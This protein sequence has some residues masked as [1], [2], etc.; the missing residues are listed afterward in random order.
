MRHHQGPAH[1]PLGGQTLMEFHHARLPSDPSRHEQGC[2]RVADQLGEVLVPAP[3][4]TTARQDHSV[5]SPQRRAWSTNRR[6]FAETVHSAAATGNSVLL[7]VAQRRSRRRVSGELSRGA[8]RRTAGRVSSAWTRPWP[9]LRRDGRRIGRQ[10][11]KRPGGRQDRRARRTARRD[12]ARPLGAAT[13][14]TWP[15]VAE[16]SGH[17]VEEHNHQEAHEKQNRQLTGCPCT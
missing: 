2:T 11:T 13:R 4:L 1:V 12:V 16:L 8:A 9:S 14:G 5:D 7:L 17:R 15:W 6:G 10:S 3:V